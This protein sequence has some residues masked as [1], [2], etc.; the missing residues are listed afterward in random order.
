LI[1]FANCVTTQQFGS[2]FCAGADRKLRIPILR[3]SPRVLVTRRPLLGEGLLEGKFPHAKAK[4]YTLKALRRV[5]QM[6]V[7]QPFPGWGS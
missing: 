4:P 3:A 2:H 5:L 1:V 6:Y 7:L